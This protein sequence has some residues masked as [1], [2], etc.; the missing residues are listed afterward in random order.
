[1]QAT[2]KFLVFLPCRQI[3]KE[4]LKTFTY[5]LKLR[6]SSVMRNMS[7]KEENARV[8]GVVHYRISASL[9]IVT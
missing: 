8:A 5:L 9:I 2:T 6:A 1:M 3:F 7:A 4:S